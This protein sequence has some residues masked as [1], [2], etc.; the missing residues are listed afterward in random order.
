MKFLW[1]NIETKKELRAKNAILEKD[2]DDAETEVE[3]LVQELAH[4]KTTFPLTL[5]DTV[6]DIQL[7]NANGRFAKKNASRQHSYYNKVVVTKSNYFSLVDR[8]L[9]KDVFTDEAEANKY[10]DEVCN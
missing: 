10:L 6:Y 3:E 7:R 8:F 2:L 4:Y 9:K 5:G 1:F